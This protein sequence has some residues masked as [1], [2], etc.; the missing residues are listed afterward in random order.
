MD[1]TQYQ[2]YQEQEYEAHVYQE[3]PGFHPGYE[4]QEGY[5]YHHGYDAQFQQGYQ[6]EQPPQPQYV[7]APEQQHVEAPEQQQHLEPVMEDEN[8]GFPE[9]PY[10]LS[11][12]PNF[13]KHVASKLWNDRTVSI[14]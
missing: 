1:L 3:Q 8:E 12:L 10:D 9:G 14:V 5:E 11:L 7:D 4:Y 6:P 13:S 2:H